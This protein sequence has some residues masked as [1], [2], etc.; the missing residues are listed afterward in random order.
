VEIV[1]GGTL[2]KGGADKS[3][4]DGGCI[5]VAWAVDADLDVANVCQKMFSA[6]APPGSYARL[7]QD[8]Y[9]GLDDEDVVRL[10]L[11]RICHCR[12]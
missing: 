12:S 7:S 9:C 6:R 3:S 5:K 10:V 1:E 2:K 4:G 11:R 8:R